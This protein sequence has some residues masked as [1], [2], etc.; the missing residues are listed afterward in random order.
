MMNI[1]RQHKETI[2]LYKSVD[3]QGRSQDF[4]SGATETER[5]RRENRGAEGAEGVMIGE[6]VFTSPTDSEVWGAS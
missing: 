6:G 4:T 5:Q 3:D 2:K 1:K